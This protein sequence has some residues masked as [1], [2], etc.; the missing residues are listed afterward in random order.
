[1]PPY[2][3]PANPAPGTTEHAVAEYTAWKTQ[4]VLDRKRRRYER[5][6]ES[7]VLRGLTL[8]AALIAE[9]IAVIVDRTVAHVPWTGYVAVAL[10]IVA[11]GCLVGTMWGNAGGLIGVGLL[12]TLALTIGSLAQGGP[13][14]DQSRIPQTVSEVEP[15]YKHGIGNFE[16]DLSEV[17]RPATLAGRTVH[18]K[19][20]I[21]RTAVTVPA[22]IAVK[23][24]ASVQSG[25]VN[26]F[27]REWRGQQSVSVT[28]GTGKPLHLVVNQRFGE[29]E[30][31]RAP[32]SGPAT[33]NSST[34]VTRNFGQVEVIHP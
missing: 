16:L 12:L 2:P 13:I 22:G 24:D 27:G 21:G 20:G 3:P 18:V 14:G 31:Q 1:M 4:Q 28:D 10:A 17:A 32:G 25:E 29:I 15:A 19:A 5:R 34:H 26:A 33:S 9:A 30:V 6:R 7:R 11:L 8:S 23:L